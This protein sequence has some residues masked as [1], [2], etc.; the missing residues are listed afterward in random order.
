MK[1]SS[2]EIDR[3][4]AEWAT[5]AHSG[6][7]TPAEQAGLEAWLAADVRHLG[8]YGKAEAVLARLDRIRAVG[9]AALRQEA[10]APQPV[11]W[12]RRRMAFAGGAAA[13]LAAAGILGAV[14]LK[15]PPQTLPAATQPVVAVLPSQ[16]ATRIGETRIVALQDGSVVT[17]NTDSKV[18][19]RF[20]RQTRKVLLDRG[21]AHFS[22]AKNK[23]RPFVVVAGDAQ[24]R[25][26]GTAF[27]VSFLKQRPV[28][29]LV[30][31]G[32][33]EVTRRG[34]HKAIR[35]IADTQTV[36]PQDAPIAVHPVTYTQVARGMAWQFGQIAFD[37]ETL[38]DAAQEFA[39]YSNTRIVVDPSISHRTITGLFA[40]NDPVGFAKATAAALSLHVEVG[41]EEVRISR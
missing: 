34:V 17:L 40:S 35:A 2:Q 33:V 29:V 27:T 9:A 36:V 24:V 41:T 7:L 26:V 4:A 22:V 21:E 13:G 23:A 3:L 19:I 15:E 6:V 31:E 28:Q 38:A 8:A 5:K 14:L 25:A 32:V 11:W 16:F 12:T 30:Q 39:R 18:T 37:N 10:P 20:T 1:L